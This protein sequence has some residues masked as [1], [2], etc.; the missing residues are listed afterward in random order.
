MISRL[1]VQNLLEHEAEVLRNPD[2]ASAWFNLGLRQQENERD[3]QAIRAL[4]Q[5]I[6]INPSLREAYL[7]LSVSYTN[8]GNLKSAHEVLEKWIDLFDPSDNQGQPDEDSGRFKPA[9]MEDERDPMTRN[10][11][12]EV[13]TRQLM[14]MA[15]MNPEGDIDADVQIAL[16][17]LFNASEVSPPPSLLC[18]HLRLTPPSAVR[19]RNTTKPLTVSVRPCWFVRKIGCC[20]IGWGRRSRM[21]GIQRMRWGI[22]RRLWG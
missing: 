6:S 4:L 15:R 14:R 3:D 17:V 10:Q 18:V 22:M 20:I 21:G 19:T 8:E 9:G 7:A 16:G 11:R 12:H 13:L 5:S 2:S 1:P